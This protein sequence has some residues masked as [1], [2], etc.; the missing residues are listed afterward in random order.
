MYSLLIQ[1]HDSLLLINEEEDLLFQIN[2]LKERLHNALVKADNNLLDPDVLMISRE[3]D[4]VL[5]KHMFSDKSFTDEL[6]N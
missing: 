5:L 6:H 4:A 1:R 2:A 3:L